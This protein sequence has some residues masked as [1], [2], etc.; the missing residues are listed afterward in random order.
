LFAHA[1][2]FIF[3]D[4]LNFF[5]SHQMLAFV[6]GIV[7]F[8]A[9]D[10]HTCAAAFTFV[11]NQ[12]VTAHAFIIVALFNALMFPTWEESLTKSITGWNGFRTVLSLPTD[13]FLN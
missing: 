4:F 2:A 3:I 1:F 11:F 12:L 10:F 5:S 6:Q 8:V 13:K 9:L 7:D